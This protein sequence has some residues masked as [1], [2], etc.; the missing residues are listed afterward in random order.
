[1]I[2]FLLFSIVPLA[3]ITLYSLIKYEEAINGEVSNRL[4][5]NQREI[6]KLFEE[7][8]FTM[9]N[10]MKKHRTNSQLIYQ[11]N[12]GVG[13]DTR[14]LASSWLAAS[15]VQRLKI[16]DREG[17]LKISL[18]KDKRGEV[19][20]KASHENSGQLNSAFSQ[21]ASTSDFLHV[22]DFFKGERL[23][24]VL[25]SAV[26]SPQNKVVGFIEES[27]VFDST[28]LKSFGR[29][30]G[31]ELMLFSKGKKD[32]LVGSH[33]D[34]EHYPPSFFNEQFNKT[35]GKIFEL[36]IQEVPYGFILKSIDW[37][38]KP[39][40]LGVGA[41]KESINAALGKVN[42]A[43]Y[44]A[45]W[46]VICLLI[47]LSLVISKIL[48]KPLYDML[49]A[50]RTMDPVS[51]D[52]VEVP[53]TSQTEFGTLAK[54][55]NAMSI[56]IHESQSSLQGKVSELEKANN[57]I[58]DTQAKLVH[59][60]KMASLGQL[61]AGV[62]HELNNPIGFIFSNMVHLRDYSERLINLVK[63]AENSP[64]KLAAKKEEAEFD[65][66][67]DD[68]PKLIKSC[69]DGAR[70]TRDIVLG[71][72]NFSRLGEAKQKEVDI[73]EGI[74]NTL[75]LLSGELKS[76]IKVIKKFG[77][78][79]KVKCFPSQLNQVFMNILTNGA[80]A[81]EGSGEITI[82][83]TSRK[84]MVDISIRDTGR[85][86]PE[87]VVSKIFDPF[88]TTKSLGKGTGLGMSITYGIIETHQ[89]KISVQSEVGKGTEFTIS[90][91]VS[92]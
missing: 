35:E 43:F 44:T 63:V 5:G 19:Q 26:K 17:T 21:K 70:R 80:Q 47:V 54:S 92:I 90:L 2:W 42:T 59:T 7:F 25:F 13:K 40:L 16:F 67:V 89:G 18:Y 65:Y 41:S 61:V 9:Q 33:D 6:A 8:R 60:A 87:E 84:D 28:Y 88:F 52:H 62:A 39:L 74:E 81:I 72:R 78:L 91:P 82:S 27:L 50:I 4:I 36:N 45:M 29:R 20:R 14:S 73:H 12:R 48:L 56:R 31:V 76:R 68:M 1:M 86:M 24:L 71:L 55:F 38:E 30:L 64:K 58:R 69:E 57:E 3:F 23:E 85:G 46:A 49:E 37:G 10:S 79:P 15:P 22:I 83:T 51:G 53:V 34:L 11:L 32:R 77:K 66:I 75:K